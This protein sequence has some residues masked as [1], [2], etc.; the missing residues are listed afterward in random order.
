MARRALPALAA[1]LCTVLTTL[2]AH[3]QP[4]DA[5]AADGRPGAAPTEGALM[6][7]L[8]VPLGGRDLPK[9]PPRLALSVGTYAG[10]DAYVPYGPVLTPSAFGTDGMYAPAPSFAD[11]VAYEFGGGDA[12][13]RVSL[14]GVP[15]TTLDD[16]DG[17]NGLKW[18]AIGAGTVL[19]LVGGLAILAYSG[20]WGDE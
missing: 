3:A 14:V 13:Q 20:D 8:N 17:V 11:L 19:V 12:A 2:P 5:W 6:V 10:Q 7:R 16:D 15:L 18:V 4:F 9:A 1:S